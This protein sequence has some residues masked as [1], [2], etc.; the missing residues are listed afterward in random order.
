MSAFA[1]G[2]GIV[3]TALAPSLPIWTTCCKQNTT[4]H[5]LFLIP[6]KACGPRLLSCG[7][8]PRFAHSFTISNHCLVRFSVGFY[9][10][11]F[12]RLWLL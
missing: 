5:G 1:S 12:A 11:A 3:D 8:S 10:L 2:L 7:H 4:P 6:V 9:P